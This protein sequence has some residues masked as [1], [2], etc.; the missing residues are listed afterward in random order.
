MVDLYIDFDGVL[1]DTITVTYKMIADKGIDL[2]DYENVFKFYRDLDWGKLLSNIK[3]LN[4]AF[5]N[6]KLIEGSGLYK[7]YI[8]TTVN[9]CNEMREKIAFIRSKNKTIPIICVP[10]GV[11]KCNVVD[12]NNAVLV[13][14]YG[15]NL[16]SWVDNNGI[17]IK[18]SE[19]QSNSFITIN[20]LNQLL[21]SEEILATIFEEKKGPRL[22]KR[23][24]RLLKNN[25]SLK[26]I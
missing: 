11:E 12:S 7:P 24:S 13:D 8:L 19:E 21:T 23:N 20:S 9:S 15:G 5:Y 6:I 4:D 17:G 1:V 26:T 14:D 10:K 25:F 2:K 3:E 16:R 18:Y 22:V